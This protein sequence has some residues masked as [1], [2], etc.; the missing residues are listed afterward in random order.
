M[1]R[2]IL[3]DLQSTISVFKNAEMLSNI[4]RSSYVLRALTNGGYQDSNMV[5]DFPNLGK[6]WYNRESI[7]NILSLAEVRKVCRITMDSADEPAMLVHRLDGTVMKFLEH[8]SG[9]YV[10]SCNNDTNDSVTG[11]TML[12]T[13]A[14]QKK[15]FSRREIQSANAARDLYRKI[16]RPAE[17]EFQSILRNN[18]IRNCPVT[19]DDAKR[20]L[21]IY[22]PDIAVIKGNT[23]RLRPPQERQRLWPNRFLPQSWSITTT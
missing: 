2:C 12:S 9:L 15:L 13:V 18:L 8:P 6:V 20:A 16:G 4:R 14:E 23:T 10:F 22:G 7:A 1:H 21:I 17:A 5:G 3:L 19:P 11:Y